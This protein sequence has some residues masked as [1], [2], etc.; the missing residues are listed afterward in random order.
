MPTTKQHTKI[1]KWSQSDRSKAKRNAI[2]ETV[3]SY[4]T[5]GFYWL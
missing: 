1:R 2:F 5:K 3:S 4:S